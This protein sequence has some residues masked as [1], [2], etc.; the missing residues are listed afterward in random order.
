MIKVVIDT[1]VVVSANLVD[2]GSSAAILDLAA[3]KQ[4]PMFISPAVLAEYH[5]V[6]HRPRLKLNPARIADALAVIRNTSTE[7]FPTSTLKISGHESDNRFYE[8][9]EVAEADY[10]ITGNTAH[11]SKDHKT[12][13][14]I[15][16]KDFIDLIIPLLTQG[17]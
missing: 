15:T 7:V 12:T 6:L 17:P 1:N 13:K 2:E 14:I 16:P 10:L 3:N 11:F 5:E 4:I 9:A 8:C